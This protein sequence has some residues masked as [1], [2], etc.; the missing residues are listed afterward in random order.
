M[1]AVTASCS[2]IAA[3]P[4]RVQTRKTFAGAKGARPP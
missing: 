2:M 3:R 4:V 1:A